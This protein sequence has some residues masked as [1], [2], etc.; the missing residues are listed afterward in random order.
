G[1]AGP[2][3]KITYLGDAPLSDYQ[4]HVME[5]DHPTVDEP[6]S[7]V[8]AATRKPRRL[9]DRSTDEIW[10]L[11]L[12][13]AIHLALINNKIL[14]MRGDYRTIGS[15]IMNAQTGAP[16]MFD[17]AIQDSGV[18]FGGKGV[19]AALSQFDPVFLAQAVWGSNS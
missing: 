12:A 2:A 6:T 14:R 4:D 9:G 15:Q 11:S 3:K 13:E 18:L 8:V 7:D 17:P 10:D 5:I 16:S 19:E 1:C